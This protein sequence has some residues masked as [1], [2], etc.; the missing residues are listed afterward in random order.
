[1]R[2]LTTNPPAI[3][4]TFKDPLPSLQAGRAFAAISV[5]LLHADRFIALPEYS[6]TRQAY[7]WFSGGHLGV[8]FFFVLSGFIILHAHVDNI[9]NPA[10]LGRYLFRRITRIYP[11]YWVLLS[12]AIVKLLAAG[13]HL[14]VPDLVRNYSLFD[15]FDRNR[16]L[17]MAWTLFHEVLFYL[18]FAFLILNRWLGVAVFATWLIVVLLFRGAA[19]TPQVVT[20]TI[21]LCFAFGMLAYLC[22]QRL[23][24][25]AFWWPLLAGTFGL[26]Y[27]VWETH[28]A[29]LETARHGFLPGLFC[30]LVVM[31]L[32]MAD[33][34]KAW[35]I[36]KPI[37][38]LG[39]ASYSIYL[40]QLA[41]LSAAF[42]ALAHFGGIQILSPAVTVVVLSI[43][44]VLAGIIVYWSIERPLLQW[45]KPR[46]SYKVVLRSELAG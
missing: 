4:Q 2:H 14:I 21:N 25:R 33:R 23:P 17:A 1:M 42:R 39:A 10:K 28:E 16:I 15:M 44:A 24:T 22:V 27:L 18:A 11:I 35:R 30:G 8:D 38:I 43:I 41:A 9:G 6:G 20:S 32:A 5:L 31:G 26:A 12:F 34:V 19:G 3:R 46:K 37:L 13:H 36:P 40:I 29:S 45:L 7:F